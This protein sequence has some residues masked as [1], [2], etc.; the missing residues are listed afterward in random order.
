LWPGGRQHYCPSSPAYREAAARLVRRLAERYKD[1]PA[2]ALWHVNNEYACH[3]S[4]CFCDESARHFRRWLRERYGSLAALN[5]AWGTAFWSQRYSDWEEIN[6][7]R[8]APT[9]QNPTQLLDWRRFC[10]DALL[11]C[12]ELERAILRELT[13]DVPLTTNFMHAFKPLNYWQW[14]AREDLVSLDMYPDPTD[15]TAHVYA[16]LNY[17]LMRSLG[18]GQPWL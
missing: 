7:P 16:A 13:P 14:A 10:S 17:D 15:P 11:E 6:P 12:F 3:V 5:V 2:L 9:F 4:E 8:A 18:R 1:H